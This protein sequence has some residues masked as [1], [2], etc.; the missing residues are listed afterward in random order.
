M[1]KT[2]LSNKYTWI[3]IAIIIILYLLNKNWYRIKSLW[4]PRDIDLETGES[5]N[6]PQQRKLEI[7]AIARLLYTDIYDTP[8]TGHTVSVYEQAL[9]L[10]DNEL[11]YL[12]K[13]YKRNLTQGSWLWTDINNEVFAFT[14]V[15]TKLQ[16]RLSK[17]G[18]K[19]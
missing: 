10:T 14:D 19:G 16:L 8:F 3:I 9:T 12:S 1:I 4:Q 5:L 13:Y 2:I 15:N 6:I 17:I 11:L 7:E 18:E